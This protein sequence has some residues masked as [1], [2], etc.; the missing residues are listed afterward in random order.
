M[1]EQREVR[2]SRMQWEAQ[3]VLSLHLTRIE[4]DDPVRLMECLARI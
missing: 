1:A 2:V 3:G 4:S